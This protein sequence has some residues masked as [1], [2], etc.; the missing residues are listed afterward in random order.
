MS[1]V[2]YQEVYCRSALNRVRGRFPFNWSLNPYGACSHRCAFCYARA[3]A[4]RADRPSDTRYGQTIRVKVNVAAVL[5]SELARPGWQGESVTI[6]TATDAYQPAEGRFRLTRA[7]L[8]RLVARSSPFS[9][10]TRGPLIV[11]DVDL[12]AEASRRATVSVAFSVPTLDETIWRVTEPGTA[13]PR[14][15]LRALSV[16]AEAGVRAGVFLAPVLPGLSDRHELLEQVVSAAG[17]AGASFVWLEMLN[18]K[19]G[20]REHF[21]SVLAEQFPE[22]LPLYRRL[23]ARRAYLPASLGAPLRAELAELR[24]RYGISNR[25]SFRPPPQAPRE[26]VQLRL[27]I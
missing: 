5:A 1:R 15:R 13:P 6:G 8:E 2:S 20:C 22:Q 25:R 27:S 23:Y 9:I 4:R 19:P 17:E 10:T 26:P 3:Y 16:L 14:Q 12:L 24:R 7:C 21:L 18:L 11:R